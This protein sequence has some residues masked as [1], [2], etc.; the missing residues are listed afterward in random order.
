MDNDVSNYPFPLYGAQNQAD[1]ALIRG[2]TEF[3]DMN[4]DEDVELIKTW[5]IC[6]VHLR[7]VIT[8]WDKLKSR[9]YSLNSQHQKMCALPRDQFVHGPGYD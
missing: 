9:H 8:E 7:S 2:A 3:Y 1:L 5:K 6:N 4:N